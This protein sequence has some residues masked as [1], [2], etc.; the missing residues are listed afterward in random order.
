MGS[1]G[2]NWSRFVYLKRRNKHQ[3]HRMSFI[4]TLF[5]AMWILSCG[6]SENSP[7]EPDNPGDEN[8]AFYGTP[9]TEVP[10]PDAVVMYEVNLRAFSPTGNLQGV[11]DRLDHIASLGVNVL[12][13]MPTYP[14]GQER[15]I[16]SPYC[17]RDY[18]AV[19][20]EFG[21]LTDLRALVDGAHARG[22][23]VI[24]DWVANH[25]SWDHPWTQNPGWHTT[26]SDGNIIHPP[27]TNWQD[28]ADLNYGNPQMRQAMIDAMLYWV[29]EANIDGF[30]CD[31]ADGV[32]VD[33]WS[34]ALSAIRSVDGRDFVLFAEGNRKDHFLAGF[35]LAFGWEFY[36]A[37]KSV[38]NGANAQTAYT[39]HLSEYSEIPEGKHWIR[40]TTNHDESA[41]DA[42]PVQLFGGIE[43]ALAASAITIFT[44]GSPLIYGSQEVGVAQPIPFFSNSTF[45]WNAQPEMLEAYRTMLNYYTASPAARTGETA[46]F[47]DGDIYCLRKMK[48]EDSVLLM[49]NTRSAS[50]NFAIPAGLR[51][52]WQEVENASPLTLSSS[53][54]LGPYQVLI[55]D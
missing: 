18:T 13:L 54:E 26:D 47:G 14:I 17:I 3:M 37:I 43:G 1:A 23:A 39:T 31:Y 36:G 44:G 30:R 46:W 55:L 5:L 51:G 52:T 45:D 35:D 42:T 10:D 22:M 7:A 6:G 20:P 4:T 25:T 38:F 21:T 41:W 40:F 11:I 32:P 34:E 53:I 2:E 49:V 8:T 12:W 33:F 29:R 24:L 48:E 50:R 27:G 9:F 15:S 19:N 28:V 16:N